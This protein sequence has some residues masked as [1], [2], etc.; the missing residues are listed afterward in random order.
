MFILLFLTIYNTILKWYYNIEPRE[1]KE[2]TTM[3]TKKVI[4]EERMEEIGRKTFSELT[5]QDLCDACGVDN[6]WAMQY[7]GGPVDE[8]NNT[9]D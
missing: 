8:G 5:F 9:E 7:H 2:G 3:K 4:T 1:M 6:E